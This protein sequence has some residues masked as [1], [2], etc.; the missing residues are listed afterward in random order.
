MCG[1]DRVNPQWNTFAGF[2]TCFRGLDVHLHNAHV[3]G[4]RALD[5]RNDKRALAADNLGFS[6]AKT[7]D[8]NGFSGRSFL[9][10]YSY[11]NAQEDNDGN[12]NA[13]NLECGHE[14]SPFRF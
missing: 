8:D 2:D 3:K 6:M 4:I 13:D 5:K 7:R 1:D 10:A 12:D 14:N 11:E 9:V